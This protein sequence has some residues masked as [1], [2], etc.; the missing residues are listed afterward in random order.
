MVIRN[1][2]LA[3]RPEYLANSYKIVYDMMASMKRDPQK[4]AQIADLIIKN[5]YR[6]LMIGGMK[7]PL[8][9]SSNDVAIF[10]V[11][12]WKLNKIRKF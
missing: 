5:T 3:C 6:T 11:E 8:V 12:L 7:G 9:Y 4:E 1:G 2:R 10:F